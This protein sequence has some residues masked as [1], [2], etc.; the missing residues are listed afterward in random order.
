[1]LPIDL[2]YSSARQRPDAIAAEDGET[3]L[4][5]RTLVENVEALA[6]ALQHLA[7]G[8]GRSIAVCAPNTLEHLVSIL[9]I[10][11]T[12]HVWVPL[13]PRNGKAETDAIIAA[14][15]PALIIADALY[16]DRFTSTNVQLVVSRPKGAQS[17]HSVADLIAEF[18]QKRP[19][20]TEQS[21]EATQAIK[22]TSG[23]T[24]KPKGVLQSYR[25]WN[26]CAAGILDAFRFAEDERFLA[27]APITH[28]TSCFILPILSRGGRLILLER[29]K[30]PDI[31]AAFARHDVT[32]TYLTPTMIYM[33]MAD[34]TA[35]AVAFPALRHLIYS[36]APM[37]PQQIRAAQGLF[38]ACLEACYGQAEA[39]QIIAYMRARDFA[40]AANLTAAGHPGP[41]VE[42]GIMDESGALLDHGDVGEIVV[43]GD[44]VMTGY[45]DNPEATA[46]TITDGWLHTGDLGF[47]DAHGLLFIK[48]RLREMIISGGFNIYPGDVE[49]ALGQHPAVHECAV[50][51][52]DDPKW[53]EAVH[54][55]V[56]LNP[57]HSVGEK[58][59]IGH[60][61]TLLDSVKAP[62][63]IHIVAQL[64]RSAV[65]KVLRREA[66]AMAL[67]DLADCPRH[68]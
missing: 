46:A 24:G 48:G 9:A 44:L 49:G 38:G 35:R 1:M 8:D 51:G 36:G 34:D 12:A 32:A 3:A 64:P 60:V 40:D 20:R 56:E 68:A 17:Q 29:P 57:G 53:G 52:V 25:S 30:P 6:S 31:L 65:G 42:I 66:K 7:P 45:L 19:H 37:R 13:N 14:T 11:S 22:F 26:A 67:R 55:A 50:F 62:K 47:V 41:G 27:A 16:L 54:A 28:G 63:R 4:T 58:E 59:L 21:L 2:L 39:P 10:L 23:S 18:W 5:Y 15:G 43:R 33:L 61:K